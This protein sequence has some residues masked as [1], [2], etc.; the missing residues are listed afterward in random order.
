MRRVFWWNS[1]LAAIIFLSLAIAGCGK[2]QPPPEI[3]EPVIEAPP[4]VPEEDLEAKRRAEEEEARRLLEERKREFEQKM[5]VMIHFDFDTYTIRDEYRDVLTE[6]AQLLREWSTV[7]IQVEGH[8]DEWGTNEY[9]LALGERRANAAKD[10]LAAA[11]VSADRIS[12][13]SF[14]EEKPFNPDHSKEAWK[15]NRRAEFKVTAW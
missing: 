7:M 5:S 3:E 10:F 15:E 8:C 13:V 11:G 12:T 4:A 9:N 14:G 2:K 1:Y 6:K